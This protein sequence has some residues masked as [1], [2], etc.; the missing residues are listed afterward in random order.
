MAKLVIT[1]SIAGCARATGAQSLEL[2]CNKNTQKQIS[3]ADENGN[4]SIIYEKSS[5]K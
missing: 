1:S 4:S 5:E 3:F 2:S